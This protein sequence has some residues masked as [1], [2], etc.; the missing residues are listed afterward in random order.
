MSAHAKPSPEPA[1]AEPDELTPI[2]DQL[3][4]EYREKYNRGVF[5][6]NELEL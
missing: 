3:E 6:R 2:Y 1:E 4:Q 5:E